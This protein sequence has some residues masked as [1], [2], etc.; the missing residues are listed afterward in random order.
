MIMMALNTKAEFI[1]AETSKINMHKKATVRLGNRR[2]LRF[3]K[4]TLING[5]LAAIRLTNKTKHTIHLP[6][7]RF[8]NQELENMSLRICPEIRDQGSV[9]PPSMCSVRRRILPFFISLSRLFLRT[10]SSYTLVYDLEPQ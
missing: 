9:T 2:I 8:K 7:L 6:I 4:R 5:H 3:R 10:T 1:N